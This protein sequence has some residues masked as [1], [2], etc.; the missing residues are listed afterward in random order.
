MEGAKEKIT[1]VAKHPAQRTRLQ[2][3]QGDNI[4]DI[5]TYKWSRGEEGKKQRNASSVGV[6]D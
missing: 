3:H 4:T 1:I 6:Q 5:A 2:E